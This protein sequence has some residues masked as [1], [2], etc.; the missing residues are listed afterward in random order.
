[1]YILSKNFIIAPKQDKHMMKIP[2]IAPN[3]HVACNRISQNLPIQCPLLDQFKNI[4]QIL[5]WYAKSLE[6][7]I[8]FYKIMLILSFFLIICPFTT[9]NTFFHQIKNLFKLK[10][11]W[12]DDKKTIF[13]NINL[14]LHESHRFL[15]IIQN[16]FGR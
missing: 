3:L 5:I 1:M 10:T 12:K 7:L 15:K 14:N 6:L 13:V 2:I 9:K 4:G 11:L 8:I 16:F